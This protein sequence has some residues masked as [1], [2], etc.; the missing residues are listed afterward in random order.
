L[1]TSSSVKAVYDV[2]LAY[3]HNGRFFE[4]P[5]MWDTLSQPGLDK[6]W[7]FHVHVERFEIKDLAGMSDSELAAWLEGRWM[8]KSRRLEKLQRD[9]EHG[10]DW[11]QSA[12]Q[13]NKK[14]E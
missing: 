2:T 3:A 10:I 7:K 13:G 5:P 4:A 12:R 14:S 9:L 8:E 11:S 6:D 1:G